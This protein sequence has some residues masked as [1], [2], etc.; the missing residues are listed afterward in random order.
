MTSSP[1]VFG[2]V[3]P[4]SF[5][6]NFNLS[7]FAQLNPVP[8]IGGDDC[9]NVLQPVNGIITSRDLRM[10]GAQFQVSL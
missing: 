2:K 10:A 3:Y 6:L 1:V 5:F 8:A 4:T 7:E 9:Q